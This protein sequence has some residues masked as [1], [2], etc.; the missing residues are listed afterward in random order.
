MTQ[1]QKHLSALE[2][3]REMMNRSSRF[4][5]LSGLSGIAAGGCALLATAY[6]WNDW[7]TFRSGSTLQAEQLFEHPIGIRGKL[8]LT[9]SVTLAVALILAYLFTWL[10]SR[11]TETGVWTTTSRRLLM[12]V[13]IP[14]IAGGIVVLRLMDWGL[15]GLIAPVCLIFYGLALVNGSKYTLSEI[16]WLGITQIIL[17]VINLWLL[18]YGLVFWAIGFGIMHIFYGTWMWW[19]Y[20]RI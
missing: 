19:K 18:G 4:I 2:D 7:Q 20:E 11:K 9:G 16:R 6:I 5:S 10:R 14:L 17:G 15:M 13:A 12:N 3:I 8:L 1:D